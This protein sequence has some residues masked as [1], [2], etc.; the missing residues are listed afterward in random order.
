VALSL[1]ATAGA[2]ATIASFLF[3]LPEYDVCCALRQP[4]ILICITFM[5]NILVARVWR[6]GCIIS[7]A[8]KFASSNNDKLDRMQVVRLKVM[9]ILIALSQWGRFIGTCGRAKIGNNTGLRRT[10]TFAD[11][12]LVTIILLVPQLVLQIINLSVL[13]LHVVC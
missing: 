9:N 6:I 8:A 5:G 11:S 4:I 12:V 10:I 1:F 13:R 3:A 2:I 7:P